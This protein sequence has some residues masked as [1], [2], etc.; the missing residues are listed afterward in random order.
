MRRLRMARWLCLE[1]G[2]QYEGPEGSG[3]ARCAECG[4][5][6]VKVSWFRLGYPHLHVV[7]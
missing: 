6:L 7:K 4:S 1:C 5:A 3:E 2:K